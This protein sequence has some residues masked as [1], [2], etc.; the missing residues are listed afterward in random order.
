METSSHGFALTGSAF[1]LQT[2]ARLADDGGWGAWSESWFCFDRPNFST[3][4]GGSACGQRG[5]G[6][7]VPWSFFPWSF[8]PL[9]HSP[10]LLVFAE[11]GLA[12]DWIAG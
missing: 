5:M 8:G 3:A 9:K 2:A 1:Q 6:R 10:L 4:D 12:A 11:A 7:L